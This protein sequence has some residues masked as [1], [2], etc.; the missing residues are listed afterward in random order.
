MRAPRFLLFQIILLC[1]TACTPVVVQPRSPAVSAIPGPIAHT[2]EL[3]LSTP[4]ASPTHPLQAGAGLSPATITPFAGT[5]AASRSASTLPPYPDPLA[6][7]SPT[8]SS[9]TP[10]SL[11]FYEPAGCKQPVED[12]TPVIVNGVQL[13][14]RTYAML[15]YAAR[16]YGGEI[17]VAG[18]AIQPGD[19]DKTD[20]ASSRANSGGGVV[21]ISVHHKKSS[22]V[23]YTEIE[24]L[25]GALR[26]A[27]FAAWLWGKD[28]IDSGAGTSL[29][30][31]AV[32]IG[33][34]NLTPEAMDQLTGP[35]GYFRG[36]S[37]TS[38]PD[39]SPIPD[40]HGGPVLCQWMIEKGY[41]D[42]RAES[43]MPVYPTPGTAWQEKLRLAA[44]AYLAD[45]AQKADQ[46]A[47]GLAYVDGKRESA[48]LMCGPLAAAI[49]RD[50]GLLPAQVGPVQDLHT[51]WLVD[52]DLDGRPWTLFSRR[53]YDVFHFDTPLSQFDFIS[54]P[55][56]PGD[57]LYTYASEDGFDHM[58][59]V[60]EVDDQ[61]RAFTV[62][63]EYQA[64]HIY[65]IQRLL[66]YD[67]S[68]P[69][70][71][72]IH[73]QWVDPV[74]G[75]TGQRGF[76][77]L[78][79]K[80][81]SLPAG[82]LYAYLVRPGDTLPSIAGRFYSTNA[83]IAAVNTGLNLADLQVGQT[84]VVPVNTAEVPAQ[85][86]SQSG[87]LQN[88]VDAILQTAPSGRWGVYIENF[89]T[90]EVAL[91]NA[92][93]EFHPASTV[94]L[95]VGIAVFDWLDRHPDI[96]I[97]TSPGTGDQRSF[98]HLLDAMLIYSAENATTAL[99]SFLDAQPGPR[100]QQMVDSWGVSHTTVEPRQSTPEDLALLWKKLY[101][102][103]LL[104]EAS[105][106]QLLAILR[107]P[108]AGDELFIGAG[109]PENARAGMAHK[110]GVTY[111]SGL[112]VVADS[113]VIETGDTTYV[114]VVIGNQV[115]WADYPAAMNLIAQIS[116]VAY[117][118][119][120]R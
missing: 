15:V 114:I 40:R 19:P 85:P 102:G 6:L 95:A 104:S 2:P 61:G 119:F 8:P 69:S 70:A 62:T 26:T 45:T 59:I 101:R 27:G 90:G 16:L 49:L 87:S 21:D 28:M 53:D 11:E 92:G 31:H 10:L 18:A 1:L 99:V 22:I 55:L 118:G 88:Q 94:K 38:N 25:V 72:V 43:Q 81:V 96:P 71:G 115:K 100:L 103:E 44:Q 57:F 91:V 39:G 116:R 110:N 51:Y 3:P 46:V 86:A 17:D 23:L 111:E 120:I 36:Y 14:A 34:K 65:W 4:E 13:N 108:S 80:G 75:R 12:Y 52:P 60:T 56:R 7:L 42:L 77:V 78:R 29:Y 54:W 105:S 112:G 64:K 98:E 35:N 76:D 106:Q 82:S 113:A 33:D 97:T 84:L 32:A 63:N 74:L 58:F 50:A 5:S 30:I 66:L 117:T 41:T 68:D 89:S 37:G 20:P 24:P 9:P 107:I 48:S 109:L 79:R 67:P 47:R 83:G 73:N 93:E